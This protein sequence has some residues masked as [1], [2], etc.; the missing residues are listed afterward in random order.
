M[1]W[2]EARGRVIDSEESSQVGPN[3]FTRIITSSLSLPASSVK[4]SGIRFSCVTYFEKHSH[5]NLMARPGSTSANNDPDY[6]H[7]WISPMIHGECKYDK[8]V[9]ISKVLIQFGEI[10]SMNEHKI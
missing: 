5:R 8:S 7:L 10:R 4:K 6:M 9:S 3:N 2:I 1:T